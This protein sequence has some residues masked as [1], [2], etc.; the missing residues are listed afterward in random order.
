[1]SRPDIEAIR[2]RHASGVWNESTPQKDRGDLLAY[3]AELEG[4]L[5]DLAHWEAA[6]RTAYQLHGDGTRESEYAWTKM[7]KAG[8]RAR[9]LLPEGE[10]K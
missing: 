7:R 4:A 6:Y 1:M 5:R 10:T 2:A 8:D 3:I 9:A